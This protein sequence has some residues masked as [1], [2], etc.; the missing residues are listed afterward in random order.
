MN[1]FFAW[2]FGFAFAGYLLK[3]YC[4]DPKSLPPLVQAQHELALAG[5][6]A[7]PDAYAHAYYLWYAFAF[8]GLISLVAMAGYVLITRRL[9]A[10]RAPP[11]APAAA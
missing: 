10:R 9:D 6:A 4:P 7:M 8:V 2:L 1:T 11:E 5:K 3:A